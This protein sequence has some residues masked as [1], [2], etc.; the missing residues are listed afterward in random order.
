MTGFRDATELASGKELD[1]LSALAS[2][3]EHGPNT[4]ADRLSQFPLYI[5]RQELS[6][7]L[8]NY[9]IFKKVMPIKGSIFYFGVY[10][11]A[12]MAT[13][14]LLSAALEPYNHSRRII[15]FD[16]FSGYPEIQ[17][18]DKTHGKEFHTLVEGGFSAD[19]TE[20][21]RE[22]IRIYDSNRALSHIPKIELIKGD[23]LK[24]LPAYLKKKQHTV[25]SM[26]VLT[27]NL[28]HPTKLVLETLYSRMPRGGGYRIAFNERRVLPWSGEGIFRGAWQGKSSDKY[29]SIFTELGVYSEGVMQNNN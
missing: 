22:W 5:R 16:T 25:V 8:A 19:V 27:L 24:T 1:V 21:L 29:I 13:F 18:E 10:Y 2:F 7:L 3:F 23:I 20:Y 26:I 4:V 12:G 9:E 14:A 15:G 6:Y 17:A 28:Y 11:G